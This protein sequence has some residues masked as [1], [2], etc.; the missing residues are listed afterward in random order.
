MRSVELEYLFVF[1]AVFL[2]FE[3]RK[4]LLKADNRMTSVKVETS[5]GETF[6]VSVSGNETFATLQKRIEDETGMAVRD[7]SFH[8]S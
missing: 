8:A 1:V 6:V 4:R 2:N 7:Q 3:F 5:T